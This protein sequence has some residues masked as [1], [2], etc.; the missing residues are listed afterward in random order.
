MAT[1]FDLKSALVATLLLAACGEDPAPQ[2]PEDT[3]T[4]SE[5]GKTTSGGKDASTGSKTGSD[6]K[7]DAS[8][9]KD[10]ESSSSSSSSTGSS[11][12][13]GG[14]GSDSTSSTG[15]DS[16][17]DA[18]TDSTSGTDSD[19]C[20]AATA[21]A[22]IEEKCAVCHTGK[23]P[24]TKIALDSEATLTKKKAAVK[25]RAITKGDMPPKP[26]APLTSSEK[27]QLQKFLDCL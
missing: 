7:K 15:T 10:D 14:K 25:A 16:K 19:S 2:A 17:S 11:G 9:S 27:E 6:T 3:K 20:D 13:D 24:T 12:K 1:R 8:T 18:G 5:T 26:S 22:F 4:G 21:I 23:E